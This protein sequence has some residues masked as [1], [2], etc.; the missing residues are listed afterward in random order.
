MGLAAAAA[1]LK[2]WGHLAACS[3]S[4]S[5]LSYIH[6]IFYQLKRF[7]IV[8]QDLLWHFQKQTFLQFKTNY[9][10][11]S[12]V[13]IMT[14]H[15]FCTECG[16]WSSFCSK[17]NPNF[18]STSR[19]CLPNTPVAVWGCGQHQITRWTT[20]RWLHFLWYFL[21]IHS[22]Y[23]DCQS[24]ACTVHINMDAWCWCR[25]WLTVCR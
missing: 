11:G 5:L 18:L 1:A 17:Q 13:K 9:Q 2:T 20:W 12:C 22:K 23:C 10:H 6:L 4:S 15:N 25:D 21:F 19:L 3:L 24:M 14:I 8:N 7:S 16:M